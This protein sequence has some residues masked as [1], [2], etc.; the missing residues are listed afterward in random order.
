M[1]RMCA[2]AAAVA[3]LSA[4]APLQTEWVR[5]R[6]DAP[7]LQQS[8]AKCQYETTA[9]T[10]GTD[11]S[12]RSVIGQELDRASRRNELM[13]LCMRAQGFTQRVHS[14]GARWFANRDDLKM[15]WAEADAVRSGLRTN[16]TANPT[17]PDAAQKSA[18]IAELNQRVAELEKQLDLDPSQAVS[19]DPFKE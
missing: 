16:L 11:Y 19:T 14:G 4:C 9:A 8:L 6:V 2:S 15:R 1:I 17:A 5:A 12:F 10:Q 18:R 13:T 7:D 3:V